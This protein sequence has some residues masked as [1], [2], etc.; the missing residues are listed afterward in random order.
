MDRQEI[1]AT[2]DRMADLR[3]DGSVRI[4]NPSI[5][6]YAFFMFCILHLITYPCPLR[7]E[8]FPY[9]HQ[10]CNLTIGQ[11]ILLQRLWLRT[12]RRSS[13]G[14]GSGLET[15]E[16]LKCLPTVA[17]L[18]QGN[19]EWEL[20]SIRAVEEVQ[21]YPDR[22]ESYSAVIYQVKL[23]RKPVY[24]VLVIQAPT[25]IMSTLAIFGIF[26]PFSNTQER[27]EKVT[28]GLNM[29]VSVS[30][31]L[32]LV[33][34]M[35][36]KASRLPLLGNFFCF[37]PIYF[38][39][40][41]DKTIELPIPAAGRCN[42]ILSEVFVTSAALIVSMVILVTHERCHTRRIRPPPWVVRVFLCQ[43]STQRVIDEELVNPPP[44]YS[45]SD[46]T[47]AVQIFQQSEFIE[48]LEQATAVLRTTIDR[49]RR[50]DDVRLTWIRV[51]D[52]IDLVCLI[53]FQTLNISCSLLFMR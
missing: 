26:S 7:I 44:P 39:T 46:N 29:F 14:K 34:D 45:T 25:F 9:D 28:L 40:Y 11:Y 48:A 17:C 6:S 41:R 18:L 33:S 32:N 24:Y 35:M 42:Y 16:H 10:L 13:R 47:P 30:M 51:F 49:L 12:N 1:I 50:E 37:A 19:S 27:R 15:V 3:F 38:A 52:H 4:S 5:V 21:V 20:L 43:C 2:E 36:P 23:K 22:N 8:S 53:T 31:M